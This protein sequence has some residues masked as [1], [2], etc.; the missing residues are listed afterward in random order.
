VIASISC[1]SCGRC[2]GRYEGEE[3]FIIPGASARVLCKGCMEAK[4]K[5]RVLYHG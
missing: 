5:A 3:F 1:S 4:Y 2:L